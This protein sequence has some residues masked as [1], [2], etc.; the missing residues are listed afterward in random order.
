MSLNDLST[1]P[2][3]DNVD[4]NDL[5][6]QMGAYPPPPQ[7]GPYRF[8]ISKLGADNFDAIQHAEYGERVKVKFDQ[9]APLVITHASN[10]AALGDV[11]QT[12]L[13]NTPRRRGKGEDAPLASDMDYLLKALGVTERPTSP[14]AYAEVLMTASNEAKEFAADVEWSWGCNDKRPAQWPD[15]TGALVEAS[16]A[17]GVVMGCG[18][19]HYQKDVKK[20]DGAFPERVA[21]SKCGAS[22]RAF[23]NLSRFRE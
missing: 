16:N 4:F 7:P 22:L 9:N 12:S 1:A 23:G 17:E 11:F 5:P 20:V 14:R 3:K 8:R 13:T 15:E 19:K 2:V 18:T 21:C 6:E 10:P